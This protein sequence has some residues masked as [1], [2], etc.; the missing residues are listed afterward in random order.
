MNIETL[1]D[2]V[3]SREGGYSD[4]P[5]DRGG[6]T[7]FGITQ[8][9][10]RAEGYDGDMRDLPRRNAVKI[11][12]TLYWERPRFAFV[13][14]IAPFVAAELFD[15]GVNMGTGVAAGFLQRTLNAL[16]RNARDYPDLTLDRQVGPKTIAALA[17]FLKL[18]GA[19]GETVLL[20]AMEALQG[21]RYIG[22]AERRPGNEAFLY[23]WLANRVG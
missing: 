23:G 13:A 21:E 22:L 16:N 10:A 20:K 14:E 15:T 8:A 9:V 5:A 7:N 3:I 2:E 18:R 12:R 17:A 4:H 6:P 19:R 11:Y 1:I